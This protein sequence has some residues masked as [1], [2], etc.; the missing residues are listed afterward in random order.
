MHDERRSGVRTEPCCGVETV[1]AVGLT[2]WMVHCRLKIAFQFDCF[3]TR[4]GSA[5]ICVRRS[6]SAAWTASAIGI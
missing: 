6:S 1:G 2:I 3:D 5:S 4:G